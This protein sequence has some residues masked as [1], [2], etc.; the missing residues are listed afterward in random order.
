MDWISPT[1]TRICGVNCQY[2]ATL[3]NIDTITIDVKHG[4]PIL[5]SFSTLRTSSGLVKSRAT[6]SYACAV[7][8]ARAEVSVGACSVSLDGVESVRG[9]RP[10]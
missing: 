9:R 5:V 2:Q 10:Q 6:M 8:C 3:T 4:G 1:D 7:P